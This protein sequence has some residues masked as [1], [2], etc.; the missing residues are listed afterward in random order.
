MNDTCRCCA[1][2]QLLA[3]ANPATST[4]ANNMELAAAKMMYNS[5]FLAHLLLAAHFVAAGELPRLVPAT[6]IMI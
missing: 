6:H 5:I 1:L 4:A 3:P 2:L